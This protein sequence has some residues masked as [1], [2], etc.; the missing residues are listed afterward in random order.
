[1]NDSLVK[2][3]IVHPKAHEIIWQNK[4]YPT[5]KEIEVTFSDFLKLSRL[6]N[7]NLLSINRMDYNPALFKNQKMFGFTGDADKSSGFGNCTVNLIKHSLNNGY[8][9]RWIGRA[10]N[11]PEV[12]K[13]SNLPIPLDIG[14]IWHEQPKSEWLDSPFLKN[15]AIVPFETTRIPYSWVKRLNSFDALFVPCKH[16]VIMMRES[17]VRIPIEIIYWGVNEEYFPKL[18]RNNSTFNFGHFGALSKRKGTDI[19]VDAFQKAFPIRTFKDVRL[20]MRTSNWHYNFMAHD[21]RIE[22]G[23]GPLAQGS[24]ELLDYY[25][26]IDIFVFPTRGE[27]FGLPPLEMMSTGIPVIVTGWSGTVDYTNKN[28]GWLLDYKLVPADDFTKNIY[29]E[30]CGSWA[31]PNIDDLIEKMRYAYNHQDEVK[32]KG[33]Y[34]AQFV[35]D[36]WTWENKIHMF[37]DALKLHL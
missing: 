26:Q 18:E 8:D 9:V 6:F 14:M 25:K 31:E 2:A 4:T 15:I 10:N 1:M 33:D 21:Y 22:V 16:N 24:P 17:G 13:L 35:R 29:K 28:N 12:S 37:H 34:A 7:I 11:V 5:N 3:H 23:M 19:L 30:D 32:K 36:N 20:K 27:G